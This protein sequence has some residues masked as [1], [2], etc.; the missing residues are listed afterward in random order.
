MNNWHCFLLLLL[1]G[2]T[3]ACGTKSVISGDILI[4]GVNVVDVTSGI[5][6]PHQDIVLTGE[7]ITHIASTDKHYKYSVTRSIPAEN[8]YII[9]G[10]WDMHAHPDDPEVWR[11]QP[12]ERQKDSLMPLFIAFGVTGIRDMG[13]S[14]ELTKRWRALYDRGAMLTPEIFACGPLLDGP[15]PMWDGS[16]GIERPEAIPEIADS[17]MAAGAD[18][19]KVYSL[20]PRE[21]YF[22]LSKYANKKN[23]PF[24]GHVPFT[25]SP[26]EA[27]LTGMKSQEHLLEIIKE[28]AVA[29]PQNFLDSIQLLDSPIA[30]SNALNEFRLT[31]FNKAKADSLY[32][33]FAEK[34]IWHCPTLSMWYKNAWYEEELP[35]DSTYISMLPGYL[36]QYWQPDQND[37]LGHRQD[38]AYIN[39]KR[40]LY[41]VYLEMV[42]NMHKKGVLILAGTDTGA[43]PLCFPGLGI[44]NELQAL[45]DAGLTPA[46]ALK[47][48]TI[49]PALF[50]GIENDYGRVAVGKVADLVILNKNPLADIGNSLSIATVIRDGRILDSKMLGGIKR[51]IRDF[52]NKY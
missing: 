28:C 40:K 52:Q 51:V 11:M 23:I 41:K 30:R 35:S 3:S 42:G 47:T 13:G 19:L 25:V 50:L 37:H 48:A 36:R 16:V 17:L 9:P 15:N 7:R 8:Q 21:T 46:E 1:F 10:L 44:H 29:P 34:N 45:V 27:A 2:L 14:L 12:G 33:L 22:A 4:S 18:F 6:L 32:S 31:N 5:L 38:T 39:T 20:L 24:A 26:S 43:N 49:N